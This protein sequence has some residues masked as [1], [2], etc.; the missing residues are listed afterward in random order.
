MYFHEIWYLYVFENRKKIQVSLNM[1]RITGTSHDDFYGD[2]AEFFI[3]WERFRHNFWGKSKHVLC[4]Y[5]PFMR[6]EKNTEQP[7]RPHMAHLH[8]TLNN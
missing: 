5:V 8:I 2:L 3:D 1:T 7:D 6:Y 4:S